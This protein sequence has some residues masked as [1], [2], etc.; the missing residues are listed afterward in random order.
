MVTWHF[1]SSPLTCFISW[2]GRSSFPIWFVHSCCQRLRS[3]VARPPSCWEGVKMQTKGLWKAFYGPFIGDQLPGQ[4][5][6]LHASWRAESDQ[7]KWVWRV[8]NGFDMFWFWVHAKDIFFLNVFFWSQSSAVLWY[9]SNLLPSLEGICQTSLCWVLGDQKN[10]LKF[11]DARKAGT[12]K[13]AS[14][15]SSFPFRTFNCRLAMRG[16]R[17]HARAT[18]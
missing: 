17:T 1:S 13:K 8:L 9:S 3:A 7:P 2:K 11:A 6:K 14:W 15:C 4:K 5:G 18:M 10:R 16:G 12:T